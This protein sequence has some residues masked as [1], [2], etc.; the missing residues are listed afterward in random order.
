VGAGQR[1]GA[2]NEHRWGSGVA[3]SKKSGGGAHR[4]GR[5]TVG[6]WDVAGA[7]AFRWEGGSGGVAPMVS[8]QFES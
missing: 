6:R 2:A 3:L 8:R 7:A 1:Q 5:A 4:G